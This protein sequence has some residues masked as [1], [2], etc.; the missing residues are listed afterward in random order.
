MR[1]L[2]SGLIALVLAL[3]I[4]LPAFAHDEI[5]GELSRDKITIKSVKRVDLNS[6]IATLPLHKGSYK[7]TS[8]W[9]VITDVSDE[10]VARELGLNFAPRLANAT[11]GCPPCVQTVKSGDSILGRA[12]VEFAGSVDF[13]PK[14][15]LVPSETGF[16]PL[17]AQPG[18]V[19]GPGYSDL[20]SIG[21]STV[22]Y[23]APIIAVGDGPF[24]VTTHNNT[25]DRVTAI[26]TEKMTVDLQFIRALAHGK[27]IHYLTFGSSGA[28]SA[29]L[30]RGTFVP[31]GS[32][33]PF[34]NASDH[35]EGARSAIFTFTNGKRGPVVP[36]AQG[37][38]HVILDNPPG[39][40][41]LENT[42]LLESLRN[43]G[44]AHNVLDSFP[45]LDEPRLA[46]LYTPL[47]DLHIAVWS[48]DAVATG[49]NV[50]QTDANQIR[51]LAARGLI[52]SPGGGLL[53]SSN[54]VV[55]CPVLGFED[56]SPSAPLVAAPPKPVIPGMPS[57]GGGGLA[58]D[59]G[60]G[61]PISL[62]LALGL[63]VALPVGLSVRRHAFG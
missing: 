41:N 3:T 61:L 29:V 18:S 40:I 27:E 30:E 7:G 59:Q 20:I 28:L 16:P 24:D 32:N 38:M 50:G 6:G 39:D 2:H 46:R 19:A 53:G 44:D 5:S 34:A 12:D 43:D 23:N 13:T 48:P 62:L 14:R 33:L 35:P 45:T 57:T 4:T 9:Y 54:A 31:V 58:E 11:N 49:V 42:E 36:P 52:T 22:V 56:E 21:D 17:K 63:A 15:I 26:D 55:N 37:L 51:Q 60:I 1:A 47:W 10:G 25:L 8:V